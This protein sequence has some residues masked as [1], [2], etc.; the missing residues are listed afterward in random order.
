MFPEDIKNCVEEQDGQNSIP[1]HQAKVLV[2]GDSDTGKTTLVKKLTD[3]DYIGTQDGEDETH[4][5]NIIPLELDCYFKDGSTQKVKLDLWDFGGHD[6]YRGT[7]Q[8]FLT[9]RSLYIIV[10]Q[11]QRANDKNDYRNIENWL[12]FIKH[13]GMQD[14]QVIVVMT[15]N[16]LYP[17]KIDEDQFQGLFLND[18]SFTEVSSFKGTGIPE[19]TRLIRQKIGDLPHLKKPLPSHFREVRD[20]INRLT[21]SYITLDHYVYI[22]EKYGLSRKQALSLSEYMHDLGVILHFR[23]DPQLEDIVVLNPNWMTGAF[24]TLLKNSKIQEE[25]GKFNLFDSRE[26]FDLDKYYPELHGQLVTFMERAGLCF[27]VLGAG[28]YVIPALLPP[29]LPP[30][31]NIKKY[32]GSEKLRFIYSND[33]LTE[34]VFC[35]F[36]ARCCDNVLDDHFWKRGVELRIDEATALVV[37]ET[38]PR[39]I[40]VFIKGEGSTRLM[41]KIRSHFSYIHR[42]LNLEV[43]EQVP[44]ICITCN[45]DKNPHF[46]DFNVLKRRQRKIT[47]ATMVCDKSDEVI[48][49][50]DLLGD[51][52]D[53][54]QNKEPLEKF[55]QAILQLQGLKKS[56]NKPDEENSRNSFISH[57]LS[58]AGM[59]VKDQTLWGVSS[60][61]KKQGE[62]DIKIEKNPWETEAIIE[63]FNYKGLDRNTIDKH[64]IKLFTYDPS[65]GPYNII[66]VYVERPDFLKSWKDYFH[67]LSKVDFGEYSLIGQPEE[68]KSGYS[69]IKLA[70]TLH[71]RNDSKTE[72]YHFFINLYP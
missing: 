22:C 30:G 39:L 24:Y 16:E 40:R 19:L 41:A 20:E 21:D 36:I 53:I 51:F 61:G 60:T 59:R 2:L 56:F 35:R 67:H 66:L 5:I 3:P 32:D 72:V 37:C 33:N 50:S 7:H 34:S 69:D 31:V 23:H 70:R 46:F 64:L 52:D 26:Y 6:I 55:T 65:G 45:N 29:S 27:R 57:E 25:K 42:A 63:A 18:I 43:T 58:V 10:W 54:I 47:G 44:C 49:I 62:L 38:L 28:E 71:R 11:S 4:G 68:K 9:K 48:S 12:N 17:K 13:F 1:I 14:S 15:K 8:F